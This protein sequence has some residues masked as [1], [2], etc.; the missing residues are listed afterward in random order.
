[1]N[2]IIN[3]GIWEWFGR[4]VGRADRITRRMIVK[5]GKRVKIKKRQLA[6]NYF[7]YLLVIYFVC[8]PPI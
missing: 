6:K 4:E 8:W 2:K 7:I 3:I 5:W 1:M